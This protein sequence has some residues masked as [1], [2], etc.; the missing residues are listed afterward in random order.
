MECLVV[1]ESSSSIGWWWWWWW[2]HDDE[3]GEGDKDDSGVNE[4]DSRLF[5]QP[6]AETAAGCGQ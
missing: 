1:R 3:M 2:T 4:R 5:G 6:R